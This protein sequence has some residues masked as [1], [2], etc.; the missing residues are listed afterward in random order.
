MKM[1]L[2]RFQTN[3]PLPHHA[4]VQIAYG[5]SHGNVNRCLLKQRERVDIHVNAL[6]GHSA[7]PEVREG[8]MQDRAPVGR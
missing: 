3:E 6:Q 8:F 1:R 5:P 4:K 7:L 2:F